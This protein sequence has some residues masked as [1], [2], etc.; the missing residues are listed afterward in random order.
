M[1]GIMQRN[2]SPGKIHPLV[3]SLL[4]TNPELDEGSWSWMKPCVSGARAALSQGSHVFE[5]L[6]VKDFWLVAL[7]VAQNPG[8]MLRWNDPMERKAARSHTSL[9]LVHA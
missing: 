7:G 6:R 5:P 2:K 1:P 3:C 8:E 9:L 4:T